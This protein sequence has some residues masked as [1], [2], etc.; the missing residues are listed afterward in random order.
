MAVYPGGVSI[1]VVRQAPSRD[2]DEPGEVAELVVRFYADVAQDDLLGPMF[3]DVAHVDWSEHIPKLAA[4]WCRALFG[5][6]GYS[7][8][9]F[10]AH[11]LVHAQRAFTIDHFVRWLELFEETVD[12]GWT[13]PNAEKIKTI[14]SNV[15]RVHSQQLLG[16]TSESS[17]PGRIV[18]R[19]MP[20][21][22]A[23]EG[24]A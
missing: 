7:G 15:A 19:S 13:G 2:L 4:F 6:E 17:A 16:Q 12:L 8:N 18:L 22:P 11:A 3:N 20:A 5:L 23:Q 10:R 1:D 9:P 21:A 24:S 14:A